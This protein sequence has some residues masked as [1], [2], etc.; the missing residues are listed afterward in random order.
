MRR[1]LVVFA[2]VVHLVLADAVAKELAAGYLKGAA[3]LSVI[4]GFFNLA[5]VE[6]RGCAWGMFQGQVWPLAAFAVVALAFLLWKRKSIFGDGRVAAVAEVLLY[7]GIVGN[8]IDRV[9]RGFVI[10]F[11]DFH[12]KAAYH[13]PCFNLADTFITVAAGLLILCSFGKRT[14]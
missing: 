10:D 1:Y 8:L 9:F 13:F 11:F 12:W 5:Y 3:P 7:A 2:V 6:N 4:P 14:S